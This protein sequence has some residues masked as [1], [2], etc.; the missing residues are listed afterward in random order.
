M[1]ILVMNPPPGV[2]FAVQRGKAELLEPPARQHEPI[3]FELLLRLGSP[4]PDGQVNFLGEFAQGPAADRFIYLNS[5]TL[6]GQADSPWTR[7]AKLKL[8]SIPR[9]VVEAGLSASGGIIEARVLGTMD[10]GGPVCAS[11][12]AQAVVWSFVPAG[13]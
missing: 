6:A 13:F 10:D 1:R 9:Q 4:L 3:A 7:R 5:G 12:K 2:R 11:V 8:A